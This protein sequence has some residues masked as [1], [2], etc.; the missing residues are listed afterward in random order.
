M[1]KMQKCV[2]QRAAAIV[3]F[4]IMRAENPDS[5]IM[6]ELCRQGHLQCHKLHIL[7]SFLGSNSDSKSV[8]RV[9]GNKILFCV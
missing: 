5:P 6:E 2:L 3:T 1:A 9:I 7:V 4:N 8:A